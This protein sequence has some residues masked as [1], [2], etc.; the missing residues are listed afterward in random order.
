MNYEVRWIYEE[1]G[2]GSIDILDLE[3][4]IIK[5]DN[6]NNQLDYEIMCR[7]VIVM[8]DQGT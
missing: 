2:N 3:S 6:E 7:K 8:D 4:I 1:Y 5:D